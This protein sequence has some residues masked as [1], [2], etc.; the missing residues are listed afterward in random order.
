[1]GAIIVLAGLVD[2]PER[3]ELPMTNALSTRI[4]F[5]MP[6]PVQTRLNHE[7]LR[8]LGYAGSLFPTGLLRQSEPLH[9]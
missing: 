9:V 2:A 8:I 5:A 4:H 1:M 6:G 3:M 7:P